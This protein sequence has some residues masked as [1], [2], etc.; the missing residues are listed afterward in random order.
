MAIQYYSTNRSLRLEG[1]RP[2]TKLVSFPEA[3]LMG[4]APDG[5]LF[6]PAEI[7]R[8]DPA[9]FARLQG[10]PYA[11]AAVEVMK[12]YLGEL[13][14][15]TDLEEICRRAYDFEVPLEPAGGRRYVL[16]LDRGP[17][18]SFKDFAARLMSRLM[19]HFRPPSGRLNVL[20]ATSGDTG[21]AI[22]EAFKGVE[23]I[24]VFIL[25]PAGEVSP[26][27]KKQLD[28]IGKNVST[29]MVSGKFD[30]CQEMVKRAFLDPELAG[31]NLTSAN[32]INIGRVLPQ[33]VYYIWAYAQVAA[34]VEKVVISVPSGNFGNAFGCEIARRM[35]LSLERLLMPTNANDEFPAFLADGEYRK[36]SPSRPCISNAMNVGH[37]S[38]L[39]RFFDIYGGMMDRE[40]RVHRLPEMDKMRESIFS[41]SVSDDE[42]R[43]TIGE[44]WR[45]RRLLL[46][47][48]GAVG[49][50]GLNDFLSA[51]GFKGPAISVETAHPAKFPEEIERIL[52]FTPDSPPSLA[53]LDSREGEAINLEGGYPDFKAFLLENAAGEE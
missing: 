51:S 3:L 23:G 53:A 19:S 13:V 2:F 41:V 4:Q 20:V 28:T 47:P 21:S 9:I 43:R 10:R 39:A 48:H 29:L 12:L 45:E 25:Y 49:W 14:S 37:P 24:D 22:G 17:T 16:R 46:E 26:R 27:Q 31:L 36:V 5:G 8:P 50:K 33:C 30:D 40:G 11:A 1:F 34:G 52:G 18:A 7:P 6:M 42:T 15:G 32:S 44:A 38:N 35:G